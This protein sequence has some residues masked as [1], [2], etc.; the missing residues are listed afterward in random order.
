MIPLDQGAGG[1]GY[2]AVNIIPKPNISFIF[3]TW[4]TKKNVL[5]SKYN[6]ALSAH[7]DKRNPVRFALPARDQVLLLPHPLLLAGTGS[8][9]KQNGVSPDAAHPRR[10][11]LHPN[12]AGQD[13]RALGATGDR[14]QSRCPGPVCLADSIHEPETHHARTEAAHA[15]SHRSP[16][17]G[18]ATAWS[19]SLV[20]SRRTRIRRPDRRERRQKQ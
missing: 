14:P 19:L 12:V 4:S 17:G 16:V 2:Q 1:W 10:C 6:F 11:K 9:G 3:H 13:D 5:I 15:S 20:P 18:A 7:Q 8:S